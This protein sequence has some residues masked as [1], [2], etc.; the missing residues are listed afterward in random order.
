[1]QSFQS[2][3]YER[4]DSILV[5]IIKADSKN[6]PALHVLGLIKASQKKYQ[7][8]ADLLS[9]A[10]RLNPNEPS[11]QYN[12]AKSLADCG[13]FGESIP[14]HKKAVEL[15]PN[16]PEA[17]LNYGI[18]LGALTSYEDALQIFDK[19]ISIHPSYAEAFLNRGLILAA[20]NRFDEANISFESAI[21]IN[22]NSNE[23]LFNKGVV[24]TRLNK[25]DE[26][27]N[28]YIS[29]INLNPDYLDARL[30][31]GV[32]LH[33]LNRF[34]EAIEAFDMV[35]G[36]NP[37]HYQAW[38]NKGAS[39]KEL[40]RH[41]EALIAYDNSI[42]LNP[43]YS[44][45]W[46]NK[47]AALHE[48]KRFNESIEA[49]QQALKL[50]P[51]IDW[52]EGD[53][54]HTKMKVCS[55]DG[56]DKSL[57]ALTDKVRAGEKCITPFP[58]LS[59]V[60]DGSLHKQCST[61][62][63]DSKFPFNSELGPL[64]R[65]TEKEKIRI[66]YFSP[67]FRNHAV[68]ALTVQLFELHNKKKFEIIAFSYGPDDQS[69]MR[70][71]LS[72]AFDQFLDVSSQS[73]IQIAQL[74]RDMSIDIAIDLGGFTTDS[75]P[76]IFSYR[77]APIQAGYIGYLGTMGANYMDYLFADKT[78][79]PHEAEQYYSEKI[80]YLP[81]YQVNDMNR[82]ISDEIF[83]RESLGLPKDKFVFACFN[84]NYK[85][86]P[87]TFNSWMNIL[88]AT[89]KGVLYL[90]ADNPWSKDNLMKEAE[91]RG[92][93]A[94]RLIFGGRIDADQYLARYRACD[95]FLDTT[96]YNAGTTAS[97][98]LWA[99]LPVLTLIGQ[100]FPS[101]VA[102]SLLNAVGL[103]ELVTSSA[104]EYEIRAIELAMNPEMMS[105]IKLKL[106]NNQLTTLLFDTPRFTES[107]EAVYTKMYG[108]YQSNVGPNH[109]SLG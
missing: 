95:L 17:L 80:V 70:D 77:A 18:T 79:I 75:R 71:R 4:A 65:S 60:D 91:A 34:D 89:P 101:R 82:K 27:L 73:D 92:V 55:W 12:L 50:N 78:I 45:V 87:A 22:P 105:A 6:L 64:K 84:N 74:A 21:Q 1:M 107:I 13:S 69:P 52:I 48:L 96:P 51:K 37:N 35:I 10:A 85:I 100:S 33:A 106:V 61:I 76:G 86:L 93:K 2:G 99:G 36:L 47:A 28:A 109:I 54:L 26:A 24:L 57:I 62:Y 9:R 15:M 16:N 58:L 31:R 43:E 104:A 42:N 49:Y 23:A 32:V 38:F 56:F 46:V 102:S 3:N 59:L 90:Y 19:A 94:D 30:N 97:D 41:E 14:H 40:Q 72:K 25:L 11:I 66:G 29:A 81:S 8:A 83:S 88:K 108:D 5:K 68:S 98:A 39:L 63:A 44:D 53:L 103:P 7:E 20:L 67:D